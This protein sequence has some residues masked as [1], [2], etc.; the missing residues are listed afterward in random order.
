MAPPN[1]T[2]PATEATICLENRSVGT[3]MTSVDH[4]CWP[5]NAMLKSTMASSVGTCVTNT[6]SGM[7]AALIPSAILRAAFSDQS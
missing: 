2:S 1:P 4:D 6:M 3:I 5:K 7:T